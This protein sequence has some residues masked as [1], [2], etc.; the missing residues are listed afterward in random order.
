MQNFKQKQKKIIQNLILNLKWILLKWKKKIKY[1]K[2]QTYAEA[3]VND[4]KY[5]AFVA[6]KEVAAARLEVEAKAQLKVFDDEGFASAIAK[7]K[8]SEDI[9]IK[10]LA[11]VN[12][13][14]NTLNKIL[15]ERLKEV[16]QLAQVQVNVEEQILKERLEKENQLNKELKERLEKANQLKLKENQLNKELKK[17]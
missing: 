12:V 11:Q 2:L 8:A 16:I 15:D 1:A 3:D 4:A 6:E 10:K 17:D 7:L 13:E 9:Y 5:D 14:E